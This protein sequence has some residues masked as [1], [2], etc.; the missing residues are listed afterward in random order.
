VS[1]RRERKEAA[2]LNRLEL[3]R[4]MRSRERRARRLR[5]TAAGAAAAL[6]AGAGIVI[7]GTGHSRAG[8]LPGPIDAIRCEVSEQVLFHVHSHLAIFANGRPLAVSEGIGIAPPQGVQQTSQ[9][10]FVASGACFYWLHTH[11]RDGIIHIE[12]PIERTFTLGEFFDVWHQ[13]LGR[14]R[15]AGARG[16]VTAYVDG[17]RVVGDPRTIGLGDHKVVQLDV[18]RPVRPAGFNFPSGV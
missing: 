17:H 10:P 4:K 13:P 8:S 5:Y 14:S 1:S 11:A 3:E 18:G 6:L 12:S 9:G 16:P 7:A 15:V 2:R